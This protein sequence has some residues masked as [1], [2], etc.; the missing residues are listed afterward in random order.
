MV[1]AMGLGCL[2]M[3]S[4]YGPAPEDE[5]LATIAR[6]L[7]LGI[8]LLDT[9]DVYGDGHNEELVGRGVAHRRQ[10]AFIAT[11]VG[12]LRRSDGS[13]AVDARPERIAA[14]CEDSLRR[15]KIE[16]IDLYYLHRVDPTVPV[17]ESIGA[18]SRLVD[19]GKVRYLGLS[20]AASGLIR[21]AQATHPIAA[22]QSEYSLWTRDIEGE[23]LPT[24]RELGIALVPYCPLG[25]GL[26]TATIPNAVTLDPTDRR[27]QQT[28]FLGRNLARNRQLT[29]KLAS[30]AARRGCTPAQLALA[31]LL[32]RDENVVPIPGTKRRDWL[33]QNI[34]AARILLSPE[35]VAALDAAYPIG[36]AA[37]DDR[38]HYD[39]A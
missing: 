14:A 7:D 22:L 11:K 32:S 19:D 21:R 30:Y 35:E 15:L 3:S 2:G 8:T 18:M 31:W 37:G 13:T 33:E 39:G 10:D 4:S 28:R 36:I 17:E 16:V 5:S 1:S 34:A 26:L 9:A 12:L 27:R 23:I 20:E 6:A 24:I 38:F 25:R 29:E